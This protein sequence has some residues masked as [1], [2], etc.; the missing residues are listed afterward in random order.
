[1]RFWEIFRQ[2]IPE[3]LTLLRV[4]NCYPANAWF[5]DL[6]AIKTKIAPLNHIPNLSF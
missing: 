2:K 5:F 6:G 3:R 1:M 4:G